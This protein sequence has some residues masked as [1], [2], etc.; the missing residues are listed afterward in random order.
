MQ[1]NKHKM[2][3][4]TY[5]NTVNFWVVLTIPSH[6]LGWGDGGKNPLGQNLW[7]SLPHALKNSTHY[8]SAFYGTKRE[9]RQY[10]SRTVPT[11]I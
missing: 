6:I 7:C 9:V 3:K 4:C 10:R 8:S 2:K 5:E 11:I 1:K